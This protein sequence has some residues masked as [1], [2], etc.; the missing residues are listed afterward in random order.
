MIDAK[1]RQNIILGVMALVVLYG[2][3]SLMIASKA[4]LAAPDAK[5]RA[6]ELQS[7]ITRTS[8][9]IGSEMPSPYDMYVASRAGGIWGRNP[10]Y[11]KIV[12]KESSR[13]NEKTS[14]QSL[15]I[16]VGYIETGSR[17]VAVINDAEYVVGD[18]LDKEGFYVKKISPTSVLIEDRKEKTEFEVPLSE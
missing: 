13:S 4:K 11:R 5:I 8:A 12:A 2:L 6:A 3:Y 18:Q 16:F 17:K 14:M 1:K 10:F 15:F 9:A 7:F